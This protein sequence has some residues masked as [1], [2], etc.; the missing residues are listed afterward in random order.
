MEL[1]P[2]NAETRAIYSHMLLYLKRHKEAYA[3][4]KKALE[5]DPLNP[6][7]QGFAAITYLHIGRYEEGMELA[8]KALEMVPNHPLGLNTL[9]AGNDHFGNFEE[10][11]TYCAK[12]FGLDDETMLQVMDIFKKQGYIAALE[13]ILTF[14]ESIPDEEIPVSASIRIAWLYMKTGGLDKALSILE[15]QLEEQAADLHYVFTGN[16]L[17]EEIADHPRFLAIQEKM[18]LPPMLSQ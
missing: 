7:I 16:E 9:W 15:T 13:E 1:N 4:A 10:A 12:L 3:Q 8:K 2:N 11:T 6:K 17:Y 18:G 14:V 5:L